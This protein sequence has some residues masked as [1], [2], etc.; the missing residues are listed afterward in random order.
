MSRGDA[1]RDGS[2]GSWRELDAGAELQ[3]AVNGW[4][5]WRWRQGGLQPGDAVGARAEIALLT[6]QW[7]GDSYL[8]PHGVSS[9][10]ISLLRVGLGQMLWAWPDP[11]HSTTVP[12]LS[13]RP[14]VTMSGQSLDWQHCCLFYLSQ[15]QG[16]EK[17]GM[18]C[19][20]Y[21]VKPRSSHED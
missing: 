6:C 17:M 9:T 18:F 13:Q 7:C 10:C 1:C 4:G 2:Q 8:V 11:A 15:G 3:G 21:W 19:T 20:L 14:Q 12:F 5:G 16:G